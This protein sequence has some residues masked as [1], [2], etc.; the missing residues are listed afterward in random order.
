MLQVSMQCNLI[1]CSCIIRLIVLLNQSTLSPFIAPIPISCVLKPIMVNL[2]CLHRPPPSWKFDDYMLGA[3]IYHGTRY[4]S[5][6]F[7]TQCS[8]D[9]T[10]GLFPR[11]KFDTWISFESN[12]ICTLPRESR[13]IF[14]LYGCRAEPAEGSEQ[15]NDNTQERKKITTE[16]GWCAVQLFDFQ[17]NM[18]LGTYLLSL[19]PPTTDKFLGP[20]PAKGSHPQPDFCPVLSIEVPSYGGRIVFP[21]PPPNPP[22]APRYDFNSLD[23]NLQQ[24]LLDTAEQGYSGTLEKREVLWEKRHYLQAFPHALPK[25]L[26]AAHSWDYASLIDLHSLLNSWTPLTPL[27]SLEL[28]LPRYPDMEVRKKAVKWISQMP[29]DQLVDFLPQLL[30][31][32]K[33]DTYDASPMAQFLLCKSLE[34]PRIAHHLYWLL[35]HSLP[36]DSP[37]NS[38]D[39]LTSDLDESLI[40]QARYHRRNKMMLRGLLGICGEKLSSRFLSQN[41]MCKVR[42]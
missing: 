31:A 27:Q 4:I 10:G 28:L 23:C 17:S 13:L 15:S 9:T 22:S 8:N 7:V 2:S 37:Q 12:P 11:L 33:H 34:S 20:A 14:V 1:I 19:W 6:P 5:Q 36:G 29:N 3:Q 41:M 30:Q 39:S 18:V 25:V 26:H 32:L 16:L 40:T 38:M 35:V 24:E 21:D 42:L